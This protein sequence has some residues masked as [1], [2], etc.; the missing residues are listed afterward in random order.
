MLVIQL[1]LMIPALL[2]SDGTKD[3]GLES[4]C[5]SVRSRPMNTFDGSKIPV[6]EPRLVLGHLLPVF[7]RADTLGNPPPPPTLTH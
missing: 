1:I 4:G 7:F 2:P 3:K 6:D 5:L